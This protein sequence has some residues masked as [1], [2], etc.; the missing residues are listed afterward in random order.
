MEI[1]YPEPENTAEVIP[2]NPGTP[3]SR[4]ADRA[5]PIGRLAFP[6]QDRLLDAVG[7]DRAAAH[8]DVD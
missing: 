8:L 5:T 2:C 1:A 7:N 6:G 4:L 3:I